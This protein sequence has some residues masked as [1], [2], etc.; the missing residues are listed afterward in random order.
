MATGGSRGT[1]SSD[2]R[3]VAALVSRVMNRE[4]P[5]CS[6][7]SISVS[8]VLLSDTHCSACSTRIGFHWTISVAFGAII[9]PVTL[10]S[11]VMVLAQMDLYAALL[12]LPFPIGAISYLKARLCPLVTKVDNLRPGSTSDT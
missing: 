8:E 10:I 5:A 6:E 4:C 12:W 9:V 11:T 1:S 2:T 3:R 7:R